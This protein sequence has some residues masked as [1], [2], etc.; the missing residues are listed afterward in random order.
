MPL[1]ESLADAAVA[2]TAVSSLDILSSE[3]DVD[4]HELITNFHPNLRFE[5]LSLIMNFMHLY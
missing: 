1:T 2:P 5:I 4:A 3:D